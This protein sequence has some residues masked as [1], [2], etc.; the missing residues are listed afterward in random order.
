[1][2]AQVLSEFWR[3]D[4]PT[5]TAKL[6]LVFLANSSAEDGP[7]A[8]ESWPSIDEIA[9]FA[10]VTRMAIFDNLNRLEE[11]GFIVRGKIGVRNLYRLVRS[12]AS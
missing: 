6:I 5:P 8:Y 9:R 7:H 1:M 11:M 4:A 3:A 10:G 2:S 12:E